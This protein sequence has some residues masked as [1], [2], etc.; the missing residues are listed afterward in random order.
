M[1]WISPKLDF[2]GLHFCSICMQITVRYLR[3]RKC[4]KWLSLGCSWRQYRCDTCNVV[5]YKR[6]VVTPRTVTFSL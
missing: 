3:Q 5:Q 1:N 4:D 6:P 2:S